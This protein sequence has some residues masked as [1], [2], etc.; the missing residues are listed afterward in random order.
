MP[1]ETPPEVWF[2]TDTLSKTF[3]LFYHIVIVCSKYYFVRKL[4]YIHVTK[5]LKR[6]PHNWQP[7]PASSSHGLGDDSALR[8][9]PSFYQ[10]LSATSL[11]QTNRLS[12]DTLYSKEASWKTVPCTFS[13]RPSELSGRACTIGATIT[14]STPKA[15]QRPSHLSRSRDEYITWV[16]LNTR[17]AVH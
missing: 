12:F 15:S 10:V 14:L 3:Y 2:H 5:R 13:F 4:W 16:F 11:P 8:P 6:K 7:S 1:S 9:Q 17:R